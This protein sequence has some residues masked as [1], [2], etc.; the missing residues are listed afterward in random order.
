MKKIYTAPLSSVVEVNAEQA[1][2]AGS[3]IKVGSEEVG[4]S[5]SL[6][7]QEGWDKCPWEEVEEEE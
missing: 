6:T 7:S 3:P 4:A 5:G 2:L 1:I